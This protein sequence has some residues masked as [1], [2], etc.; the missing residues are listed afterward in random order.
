[1]S[2]YIIATPIGNL[3]DITLR[4]LETMKS[5]DLIACEDTRHTSIL[6]R[7]HGIEKPLTA[8]YKDNEKTSLSRLLGLLGDGKN[9]GLV[10]NAGTPL[11]SDPGYLLVRESLARGIKVF[12]V[13]GPSAL[14]AT[15]SVSGLPADR[16]IFE[17]FLPKKPG[18]R[19]KILEALKNE[20]R[21]VIFFESPY[22]IMK[23]LAEMQSVLGDRE[24]AVGRE[25]TKFYEEIYRGR[26]SEIT[27]SAVKVKGEF[28]IVLKGTDEAD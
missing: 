5:V 2:L 1:M 11:I 28:T 18:A 6:L 19:R 23:T 26:I 22:R 20:R 10:S 24:V 16:F 13:P 12:C 9:I 8:Y 3:D 27:R 21:T 17:G 7:R 15:L 4:A 14:T 25:L